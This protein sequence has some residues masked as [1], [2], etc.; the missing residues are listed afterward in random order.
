MLTRD[1]SLQRATG[2]DSPENT[3]NLAY[4]LTQTFA[5]VLRRLEPAG[6]DPP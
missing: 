5:D 2:T 3:V 4:T 1:G 6:F